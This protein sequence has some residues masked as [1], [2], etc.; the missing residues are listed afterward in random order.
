M[1]QI[2]FGYRLLV[3]V[4]LRL[5]FA[6]SVFA[7]DIQPGDNQILPNIRWTDEIGITHYLKDS[8][9]KPRLLHFWAAWCIPCRQEMPDI[10]TWQERNRGTLVIPLS[11]DQRMAQARYFINRNNLEIAPL[12]VNADDS[13][14]LGVPVVPYTIF[15]SADGRYVGHYSGIAPWLDVEFS[16]QVQRTLGT[17]D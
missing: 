1:M 16:G 5:F 9:G 12:L 6:Q 7:A 15:V 3:A 8:A 4:I 11:L 10:L 13:K 14:A 17:A 2:R